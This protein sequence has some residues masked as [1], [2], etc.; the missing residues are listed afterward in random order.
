MNRLT[1][2][3][4]F[5]CETGLWKVSLLSRLWMLPDLLAKSWI[6]YTDPF[7]PLKEFI[8]RLDIWWCLLLEEKKEICHSKTKEFN[9]LIKSARLCLFFKCNS[10]TQWTKYF[11]NLPNRWLNIFYLSLTKKMLLKVCPLIKVSSVLP[12]K[13]RSMVFP[14]LTLKW[15]SVTCGPTEGCSA[16]C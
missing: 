13:C 14:T 1:E 8:L 11:S 16:G 2:R 10:A 9:L 12:P 7:C 15:L 3:R 4:R 5:L 6:L